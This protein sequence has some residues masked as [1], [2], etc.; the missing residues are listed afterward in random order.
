MT[1]INNLNADIMFLQETHLCNSDHR[2]LNRPWIDKFFHSQFNVKARGTAILIRK[3]VH[4]SPDKVLTD[5][6][7]R[8]AIVTGTLYEKQVILVSVYAP[9][10]D[11]HNFVSSLFATIPNLDS[12]LLIM[13]GDMNCVLDPTLDR[14]VSRSATPMK[15]SQALSTLMTQYGFVDPWRLSHPSAK[16]YSFFSHAHRSFSRI[17]YFLIDKKLTSAIVS[18]Q[19]LPITVSDHATVI[20]DLHFSM[21][22]KRFRHWSL[23]PLLLA[24]ANFCKHISESITFFC[25][26][27]K[28]EETSPSILWDTLKAYVRGEII[29]FT[30]HANKLR[31]SR[32]K[33]LEES[34]ADLDNSLSNTNTP[35][36]YKERIRL[37]TELDLLLTNEAEQLLLR[38]R[39][40][41]YEHGDKAGRLLAHQLKARTAS[42]QITQIMD[43]S[44]S[45]T[46]D[47]DKINSTFKLFF[48]QLYTSESLTGENQL[49]T[50]FEN[51]D[52]PKVSPENNLKLDTALTL[53]EIKEAIQSM[54]SGKS[55]GPDGYPVEFFKR[56]SDQLA[57]LLLDMFNYSFNLGTLPPT[58]M[59]ASIS[60]IFKKGKDPLN[61]ASYRPISLLPVD[62]KI[63][64]KILARR[65]ESI[66]PQIISD[67][68]TGFIRGR[69]SYSNIRRLLNVILSPSSSDVPEAIISLDAE[70]AFDRVEWAYLFFSLRQFGFNSNFISWIKL[71]Y[72]SPYASVCTSNQ[73]SAPFSLFRGTRQGCPLSPLLF[74]LAIEPLS[75]A[76]KREAG[77]EGI[78]RW[79]IE[80]RVSL[81]ADDL[82]L[83]VR[84][85]LVSIPRILTLLDSF[86][87][88][89][90]YKLNVSKSEYFPINQSAIDIP[91]SFIPFKLANTGFT[92]LGITI[93]RSIRTMREQNLTSLTTAVKS[94]LQKWNYLPLSLAGRIQIIKMNVLPRY[95][96][97]FQCLPIFLPKSFFTAV[98][99]IISSFIWANRRP[100]ANRS[101]LCRDK[102]VGGLGLP[103]LI[104]YYWAAN[105]HK[106]TSW[107]TT[108]QS[109]W[110]RSESASC[111]S[112]L[113]ALTC[114]TLP[115][116]PSNFTSNPVVIG[117]LKIWAQIRHHFRWLTLPLASPICNNHL[118]IPAKT[119]PRFNTLANKGLRSLG[120][121]YIDGVFASFNQLISTFNLHR[122][123]FFRYF[124]L[125][126]FAKTHA[127]SF[128]QTPTP[129]GI[130]LA[131]KAKTLTKGHISFF[132]KLLSPTDESIINRIK[133]SWE[134]ELQLNFS[135][136][137]WEGAIGVVNSS[138]SCARLSLIQFKI[139]H[140]LHYSKEKLSKLYPD[141]IDGKCNRCSQTPCNLTHMFW[142]C[143]KLIKFWQLFF[144]T[145]SDVLNINITPTP[146]IAIFGK[147]PDELRT[148]NIQNNVIA[149]ASL[150]ARKRI[151]LLWKSPQS[152]SIK[153]WLH[154]ILSLLKL[155][156]I[157]FSL[158]G[159]SNRFYTHWRPLLNYLDKLPAGEVS[160]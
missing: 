13:G 17:D 11:D 112:S 6:N 14:S 130:D 84:N 31:R 53:S 26:T 140:R 47:P 32:Q 28:N 70:K 143:P 116:L 39:G 102:S 121:L 5:P 115:L 63:L 48:S 150:T 104:G 124:Q 109:I 93:T 72:S 114:S 122:S 54:S 125:R 60:L 55:P 101:L 106:I 99:G 12:H 75:A 152:P 80:H 33:E 35:D 1:H 15:M 3:N 46:S 58:L 105:T 38:S 23:N 10:W 16:Q 132:Y 142:S 117:T 129:S 88:L 86:G 9:N 77:F 4:F 67:D 83:Y 61:C 92:Y 2:K 64:A 18:T 49:N 128:P 90:G 43:E 19:Y 135:E 118:F 107:F 21:K 110:C 78:E 76:L 156:K 37:Q 97:V 45:I 44:G 71:L 73:R 147:P 108:P 119:D 141:K 29:S 111:S 22:P 41:V 134:S 57:P 94:D 151:L 100:R 56:F 34:I 154:D 149:F 123:D 62:V 8:Y 120:D 68:Q 25:E 66:M 157:K 91:P 137:F 127:T 95:L 69:H 146:H 65:L 133:L 89:S 103:N 40:L 79:S 136:S 50:F 144:K 74:A 126:N 158:R 24:D 52:L 148:T 7:G 51:L 113:L 96:Y 159:S 98:N 145:I 139:F 20:L 36:L 153:V 131:L 81:Y 87:R 82:L 27:N 85:P 42:N 155:E 30:S 160:L 138:S 59:Q